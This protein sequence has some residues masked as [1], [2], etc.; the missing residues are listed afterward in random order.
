MNH[1]KERHLNGTVLLTSDVISRPSLLITDAVEQP[2]ESKSTKLRDQALIDSIMNRI[3]TNSNILIPVETSTRVLELLS[4]LDSYW[5]ENR[6]SYH[7]VFLSHQAQPTVNA[8]RSMLEWMGDGIAQSFSSK[9]S[10][11]DFRYLKCFS[12][13][14]ELDELVGPKVVLTNF[15]DLEVGFSYD[16]LLLWANGPG[17]CV[18]FPGRP[19]SD[20]LGWRLYQEWKKANVSGQNAVNLDVPLK[21]RRRV[22]L[23]G[24]ELEEYLEHERLNQVE[25]ETL[26]QVE[27]NSDRD[28]SDS[29]KEDGDTGPASYD[30][31]VDLQS[32]S[33]RKGF[34]KQSQVFRMFPVHEVRHRS[35]D[36]GELIDHSAFMKFEQ[37][38]MDEYMD[39]DLILAK[40][41]I[42]KK[43]NPFKYLENDIVLNIRL[44]VQFIDF[45]GRCDGIIN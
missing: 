7:L 38:V 35:D 43:E 40:T 27:I 21:W 15:P 1:R 16:L 37:K 34:F 39:V 33:S 18:I 6:I 31:Y 19:P 12:S 17:N 23:E 9:D 14:T 30:I 11:F 22:D 2:G 42:E 41:K 36:Y 44:L 25:M 45:E 20:T 8:A 24:G 5:Q 13:L 28:D 3:S 29:D 32:K 26:N 4:V 10:T